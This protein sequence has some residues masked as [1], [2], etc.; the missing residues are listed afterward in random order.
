MQW[1]SKIRIIIQLTYTMPLKKETSHH[2]PGKFRSCQKKMQQITGLMSMILL[3][4]GHKLII[5]WLK[6]EKWHWIEIQKIT[7]LKLNNQLSHQVILF[8]VLSHL[9]IRCFKVDFSHI[10]I[11]TDTDSVSIINKFQLIVH[12]EPR[13]QM[14]IETALLSLTEMEVVK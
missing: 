2:G 3:K 10:Q 14:D 11:L 9:W 6:S 7:S 1:R 8:Q 12:T 4:C 13:F 5:H